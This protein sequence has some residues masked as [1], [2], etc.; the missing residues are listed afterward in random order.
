MPE[1]PYPK[2]FIEM[3]QDFLNMR[4]AQ[5]G[6]FEQPSK[7]RLTHAKIKESKADTWLHRMIQQDL[8]KHAE[9]PTEAPTLF[10]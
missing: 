2:W 6:Y 3:A 7:Y 1:A 8:I 4:D 10:K 9:K 5:K